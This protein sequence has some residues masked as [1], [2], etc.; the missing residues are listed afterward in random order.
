M[1]QSIAS[2]PSSPSARLSCSLPP[3]NAAPDPP[4]LTRGGAGLARSGATALRTGLTGRWIAPGGAAARLPV[5]ESAR[6]PDRSPGSRLESAL[7]PPLPL[8]AAALRE[9]DRFDDGSAMSASLAECV[10]RTALSAARLAADGENRPLRHPMPDT[11][12]GCSRRGRAAG[13]W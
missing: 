6:R 12:A 2:A 13:G 10:R 7:P 1:K 5:G 3:N 9:S 8:T 11:T 4:S